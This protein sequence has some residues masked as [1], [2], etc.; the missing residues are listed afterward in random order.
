MVPTA[1][2]SRELIK[3]LE[4]NGLENQK[5][6]ENS[7]PLIST[8][9]RLQPFSQNRFQNVC[10]L[11]N[12]NKK[13]SDACLYFQYL[14]MRPFEFME[15]AWWEERTR[16]QAGLFLLCLEEETKMWIFFILPLSFPI[17][18][19]NISCTHACSINIRSIYNAHLV[20]VFYSVGCSNPL[21]EPPTTFSCEWLVVEWLCVFMC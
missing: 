11:W 19:C 7:S 10:P 5:L 16:F 8:I 6:L 15:T 1:W 21:C 9:Q 18:A 3:I 14:V 12:I 17:F 2:S 13:D 4:Q 20:Q